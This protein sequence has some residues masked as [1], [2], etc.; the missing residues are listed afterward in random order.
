M[1]IDGTTLD[2]NYDLAPDCAR[3]SLQRYLESK[4]PPGSF[5][6]AVL[7]N[8]LREAF[9]KADEP[10]RE[11]LFDTVRFLYNNAPASAWGSPENV[12]AWMQ[13]EQ[14]DE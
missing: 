8:D 11:A 2:I 3:G 4:I 7:S 13:G 9:S 6:T 14:S 1:E 5:L 10:N 12:K